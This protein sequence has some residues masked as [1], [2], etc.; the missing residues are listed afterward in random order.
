MA[1][2]GQYSTE[3]VVEEFL[4]HGTIAETARQLAC[5]R[6]TVQHHQDVRQMPDNRLYSSSYLEII[7]RTHLKI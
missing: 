6:K 3:Q 4:R 5:H 7:I 2:R 1:E